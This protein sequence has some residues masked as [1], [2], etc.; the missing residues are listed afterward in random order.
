MTYNGTQLIILA[1]QFE[2]I[3]SRCNCENSKCNHEAGDCKNQA[4]SKKALYVGAICDHCAKHMPEKYM[5]KDAAKKQEKPQHEG[6][7]KARHEHEEWEKANP[8]MR[9]WSDKEWSQYLDSKKDS[10]KAKKLDSK[11][12]AKKSAFENI[13]DLV[14]KYGSTF[15]F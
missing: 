2:K 8:K 1:D 13:D 11:T 12:N 5:K 6:L 10:N 3:A 7:G 14:L 9:D 4:G 15:S